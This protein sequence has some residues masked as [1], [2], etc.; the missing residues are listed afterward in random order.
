MILHIQS[1]FCTITHMVDSII[2]AKNKDEADVVILSASY[3]KTTSSRGGTRLGPKAIMKMMDTKLELFDRTYK[4]VVRDFV[5]IY[6][7]DIAGMR[8]LS[9]QKS[10]D[11]ITTES[12]KIL[13]EGK[14]VFLLGGEHSVSH[15]LLQAIAKK[16]NSKDITV[17]QIDAHCDLRNDSSDY[18]DKPSNLAHSC[19]LRRVNELGFPL[20]QVGIRTYFKGEYE[21]FSDPKNN[22]TVFEWGSGKTA[23]IDEVLNA[24]KTKYIYITIDVDG[25]DPSVM[26]GTGT[27]VPGGLSW[28]YGVELIERA[29]KKAELVSADIVEV[30]PQKDSVLTEYSAAQLIYSM[31]AHKFRERLQ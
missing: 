31:I 19:V 13:N 4:K 10:V 6:H 15:G 14:F 23:T 18:D 11:K 16:Y 29:I 27:P 25:F 20:V 9:P 3:E 21:Y 7:D 5:K 24:I 28:E 8:F 12:E 2:S 1:I 26:P 22:V 30:S 17:L